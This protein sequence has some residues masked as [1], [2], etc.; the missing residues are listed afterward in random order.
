M[1]DNIMKYK[2]NEVAV[3]ADLNGWRVNG[4]TV[5]PDLVLTGQVPDL[6]IVDRSTKPI[7]VMLVELTVPWDAASSFK[8]VCDRKTLRYR[9]LEEDLRLEGYS[10]YNLPLEIGCRGVVNTRNM[11]VLATICSLVGIR[12]M[13]RLRANLGR[14]ALLGSYRIW[15]ARRSQDWTPGELIR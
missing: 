1:L 13:K 14:I 15:L 9:R 12:S 4:G 7:K 8:E 2:K 6:V 11:G 3:F 10:P 5:P